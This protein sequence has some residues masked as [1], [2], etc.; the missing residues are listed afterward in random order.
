MPHE[1]PPARHLLPTFL[2]L[3]FVRGAFLVALF[4]ACAGAAPI[5]EVIYSWQIGPHDPRSGVTLG[6]DGNFYGATRFGGTENSGTIFKMTAAGVVTTLVKFTRNG[7][8]N[9]GALPN[10]LVEGSDGNFYGTTT[11]GGANGYGTIFRTTPAGTLT[12]LV[13]FSGGG[14]T[15]KGAYPYARLVRGS[16]GSF[17]GTTAGGGSSGLGTIFKVT[18]AGV[19]T[20]LVQFTGDGPTDKGAY[21]TAGLV[22]GSDGNFYGM[23]KSGGANGCGTVFKATPAGALTTLVEFT[24]NG[25][26]NKGASPETGL[27]QGSDGNFYGT[28][29]DGGANDFGTV[30]KVTALGVLTTLVE[31]TGNGASNIGAHPSASLAQAGNGDFYG[32][33]REGGANNH[34]TAFK[35]TPAGILTTVVEFTGDGATNKGTHPAAR[36]ERDGGGNF[37]GTTSGGGANDFGTVFKMTPAGLLTTLADFTGNGLDS[38]GAVPAAGLTQHS[39]GNFYGTTR[40]G[41]AGARGTV[42]KVTPAG[43]LT[44]LV[45]FTGNGATNKGAYPQA[46]LLLGA[47]GNFYGTTNQGGAGG[48]GTIFR[49]TP[50][51]NLTTLVEFSG[52]GPA[53]KGAAPLA[54]LLQGSDGDLYGTTTGGGSLGA[55]TV[56]KVTPAGVLTTLV[57]FTGNGASNKGAIPFSRLVQVSGGNFYGTTSDGGS[58]GHGTIFK[59]TPAGELTTLVEFTGDGATSK[60]SRPYAGLVYSSDGNL[61]GTTSEGGAS[62]R[63]TVFKMTPAGVLTTLVHFTG[64]GL[65]NKGSSPNRLLQGSNGNFY[66]T[67][68]TGGADDN[69]TIFRMT[70]AGV[71]K[72]LVQFPYD[73]GTRKGAI[74]GA[75][76]IQGNDGNFYGT[77]SAGGDGGGTVFRLSFA[78]AAPA[79]S[80]QFGNPVVPE[81]VATTA[82]GFTIDDDDTDPSSLVVTAGSSNSALVPD[83]NIVLAGSGANRTVTVTPASNRT[84]TA[85]ITLTVSDG[86]L[87]AAD[88]FRITVQSSNANLASLAPNAGALTPAFASATTSYT[89]SVPYAIAAIWIT[90]AVAHAGATLKINGVTVL[91]GRASP[92]IALSVGSNLITTVVT[93]EDGITTK[94]YNLDVTRAGTPEIQVEQPP[95]TVLVDGT[96]RTSFG[97]VAVAANRTRT[98]TIRNMGTAGLSGLQITL[99]GPHAAMFSV[100][101]GLGGTVISPGG[102]E[103]FTVR[104]SP[105]SPGRK[106]AKLHVASN[107]LDEN[108]FDIT[109]AGTGVID[110]V[111]PVLRLVTPAPG[112]N[113]PGRAVVF[114]G[115]VAGD[116]KIERVEVALN[117]GAPQVVKG[118]DARGYWTCQTVPENGANTV[119]VTAYDDSNLSSVPI[120]RTFIFSHLRPELAGSY[121]GLLAATAD[122]PK[123]MD[124][125]GLV[126]IN[127]TRSGRFTGWVKLG[128]LTIRTTGLVL[129]DGALRFGRLRTPTLELVRK[130]RPANIALGH[131]SLTLDTAPDADRITGAL[132][133]GATV[134][135]DLPRADRALY[136][137]R[138][139]PTLPFRNVPAALA[140]PLGNK[141]RYTALFFH[142]DSLTNGLAAG[143]FP[144]G[145]GWAKATIAASGSVRIAGRLADGTVVSYSRPLSKTNELPIY[146]PLYAAKRGFVSGRV[147]FDPTQPQTDATAAGMKWFKPANPKDACYPLGWPAGIKLDFAASKFI[148]PARPTRTNQNPLYVSGRD[149]ILGLP[150]PTAVTLVL[151]DGRIKL[152]ADIAKVATVDGKNKVTLAAPVDEVLNL[153][154]TLAASSGRLTGTFKHPASG[155]TVPFSGVVYQ[156]MHMAGGCFLYFPPKPAGEAAP[157]GLSGSVGIA[158]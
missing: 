39:D 146:A 38:Q 46:A 48:N 134:V 154:A 88:T 72:T 8:S 61:Y 120:T 58:F 17:Y 19:L 15:K 37:Y 16:D 89:A 60:G 21:P 63:G 29:R 107:D 1:L 131:L 95:G 103:T 84:G 42:F 112:Q 12:T 96:A 80:R 105:T 5:H 2:T 32:T 33:T 126:K 156:K 9:K 140:S 85:T 98:F 149:N 123:P 83:A 141:G 18:S 62:G 67:T 119:V 153:K 148:V 91:S 152:A 79:I 59:M 76:L 7:A 128:G 101:S 34:G 51:G 97:S 57:E 14:T 115:R 25:V 43:V 121:H 44:T 81:G 20:T 49:I 55:G 151:A 86:E 133:Q 56:F 66:G 135:A 147:A 11:E 114:R 31:F 125:E 116:A 113:V 144:Q 22:Q 47:D 41:G 137:A 111:R 143:R 53:N 71:L 93:A 124:H 102:S 74:P 45:E 109:L 40:Y 132:M 110:A 4:A 90:P 157:S 52:D 136:T 28:T 36:L 3:A 150:A 106:T 129:N 10:G 130:A 6:S 13:E 122:S 142:G 138:K 92:A 78:N 117:G 82:L 87:S 118:L 65:A 24:G 100:T 158:P 35:M 139:N 50:S 23:T 99:D 54:G 64:N 27:V 127:V 75:G 26:S 145:E 94:T 68:V 77:T 30:F 104:F 69:G 70:P 108:P 73:K 155:R